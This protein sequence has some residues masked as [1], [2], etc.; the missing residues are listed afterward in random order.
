[1]KLS[2]ND[3]VD[4]VVIMAK[5]VSSKGALDTFSVDYDIKELTTINQEV[6]TTLEFVSWVKYEDINRTYWSCNGEDK[7]HTVSTTMDPMYTF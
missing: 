6:G 3:W 1:M 4:S 7:N 5:Y 2:F